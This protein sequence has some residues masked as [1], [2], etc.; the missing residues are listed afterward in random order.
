MPDLLAPP[1]ERPCIKV[2]AY[3]DSTEW[4]LGCGMTKPEKKAWKRAPEYRAAIH[5]NLPTRM[6]AMAAAGHR[7]GPAAGKKR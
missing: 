6:A 4:C 7:T 5:A 3:D 2:C 1:D